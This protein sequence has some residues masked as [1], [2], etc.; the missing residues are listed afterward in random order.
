MSSDNKYMPDTISL[1]HGSGGALSRDLVSDIIHP[2]FA[3]REYPELTDASLLSLAGKVM[4][5]T[6]TYTVDPPFFPGGDIGMLSVFGTCND[7]AV[8]G[9]RPRFLSAGM[10]IEEGFS[11]TDLERVLESMRRASETAGVKVVTGD[12]K[13]VPR[14][15]GGG[16]YI[17][18]CGIGEPA[19]EDVAHTPLGMNRIREGD[20][21]IVSGPLGSHGIA[22]M[23]A[24]EKLSVAASLRSDAGYLFPLCRALLDLGDGVRFMRDATRGGAAAILNEMADDTGIDIEAEET[25]FPVDDEVK[26]VASIL[27]LEP[28]EIANEGVLIAVVA[29]DAVDRAIAAMRQHGIG[30]KAA[31]VGGFTGSAARD[32]GSRGRVILT[33]EFGGKRIL[34]FPRGLLLPRIC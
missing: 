34:G 12:T 4:M 3:G 19:W 29:P 1:E 7:L 10:V 18:T 9:A 8:C 26:T 30:A 15:K 23:A 13:V 25:R 20:R 11:L 2:Y 22:V 5:T 17:N 24:R 32:G 27:G 14:G 33:T 16:V 28:L 6:D 31:E 21:I